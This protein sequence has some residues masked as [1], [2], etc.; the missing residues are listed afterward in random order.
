MTNLPSSDPSGF[1]LRASAS[2]TASIDRGTKEILGSRTSSIKQASATSMSLSLCVVHSVSPITSVL[3]SLRSVMR[4][5][6]R[7]RNTPKRWVAYA[8]TT[9]RRTGFSRST[10]IPSPIISGFSL[11]LVAK[12]SPASC[13]NCW[14]SHTNCLARVR[15]LR[16]SLLETVIA[17]VNE[18]STDGFI[19]HSTHQKD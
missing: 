10:A 13:A 1:L 17:Y 15:K 6:L 19:R 18:S 7:S 16:P 12:S 8:F 2:H 3:T 5:M 9:P 4:Y 11:K 14:T